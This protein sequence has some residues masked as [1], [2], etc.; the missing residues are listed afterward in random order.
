[1]ADSPVDPVFAALAAEIYPGADPR[2]LWDV[3]K[4]MPGVSDVH[5]SDPKRDKRLAAVGLGATGVAALGGV[6]AVS[7]T[8]A[9]N[10]ER[11]AKIAGH[12]ITP[13]AYKV[14]KILGKM[15]A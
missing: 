8:L 4:S 13:K 10:R 15:P 2:E 11:K 9:E 3:A 6:H 12:A 7:A 5:G 14:P 1:M